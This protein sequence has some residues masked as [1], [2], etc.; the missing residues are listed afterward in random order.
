M[1]RPMGIAGA[2]SS[3]P[4]GTLV[5]PSASRWGG[6]Q[7]KWRQNDSWGPSAPSSSPA[8]HTNP[9]PS[10][11]ISLA[12]PPPV[13]FRQREQWHM[14]ISECRPTIRKRIPLHKQ[15]PSIMLR[16]HSLTLAVDDRDN[17]RRA[18]RR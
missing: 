18:S 10:T 11:V 6:G 2:P 15:L 14:L 8:S 12:G 13:V 4:M 16:L 3:A 9:P 7:P 5:L 17:G 1:W